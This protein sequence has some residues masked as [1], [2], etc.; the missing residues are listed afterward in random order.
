MKKICFITTIQ[1]TMDTFVVPFAKV[2]AENG[3]EVT[4]ICNMNEEFATR[5]SGYAKCISL[6]MRRGFHFFDIFKYTA[7]LMKIFKK[8][9]FDVVYYATDNASFYSSIAGT[10]AKIPVRL[11]A[12][13]GIHYVAATGLS[14]TIMKF[15]EKTTCR[16]STVIRA[17]SP[18]NRQIAIDEKLCKPGKIKVL[19]LGGTVGVDFAEYEFDKKEEF[20]QTIR[21]Q[22][23]LTSEDFVFGFVGRITQDKGCV[24]LLTAFKKGD[25]SDYAKLMLVGMYDGCEGEL[26]ELIEWAKTS[27]KVVFTG[28]VK[29]NEVCKY[30]SAFDVMVHPTYRE[31]FGKV[32]QE[33][34]AMGLPIITT[35]VPGP[36]E[37]VEEG[38]SGMLV[39]S[40]DADV[41]CVAMKNLMADKELMG[42]FSINGRKRAEENFERSKMVGNILAD[43]NEICGI[44]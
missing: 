35:D 23:G 29:S 16:F 41:L 18:K 25:F 13:W 6:P 3:Y 17:Q 15:L 31:G 40:K 26:L 33:G 32:L 8:E 34:L 11:Y 5:N 21:G 1:L 39:P 37:V 38:V 7:K 30:M 19:G 20:R 22:Y 36:S 10:F 44:E 4:Y 28:H 9:K 42:K 2:L 27:E 12:Q 24:E 14:R 43:L